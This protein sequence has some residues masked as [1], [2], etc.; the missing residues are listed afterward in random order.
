MNHFRGEINITKH[1][2]HRSKEKYDKCNCQ[3]NKDDAVSK[4]I[5]RS[6]VQQSDILCYKLIEL[7]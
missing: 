7:N 6:Y 3:L 4:V 2:G 5:G 1:V